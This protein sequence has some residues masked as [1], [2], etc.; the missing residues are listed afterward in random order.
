MPITINIGRYN[1][2]YTDKYHK[3]IEQITPIMAPILPINIK[4]LCVLSMIPHQILIAL[5]IQTIQIYIAT[6]CANPNAFKNENV[7]LKYIT[8]K[9]VGTAKNIAL[10]ITINMCLK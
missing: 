2:L 10:K 7:P 8:H 6:I 1:M 5:L 9:N 4:K 3:Y